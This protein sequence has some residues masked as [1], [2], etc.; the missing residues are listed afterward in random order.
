V[1]DQRYRSGVLLGC[2]HEAH[3]GEPQKPSP[4]R[5]Q[6][7]VI[8]IPGGRR[9]GLVAGGWELTVE[10]RR[11]ARR[12]RLWTR[13]EVARLRAVEP[14]PADAA[15]VAELKELFDAALMAATKEI[16]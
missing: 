2:L 15:T 9:I 11:G 5:G 1:A 6:V 8:E 13:T 14:S 3:G 12:G 7:A 10:L 4:P 16:A